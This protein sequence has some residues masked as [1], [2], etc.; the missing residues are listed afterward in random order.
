MAIVFGVYA[1]YLAIVLSVP[2]VLVPLFTDVYGY[3]KALGKFL[4]TNC[5]CK[6]SGLDGYL[7][8]EEMSSCRSRRLQLTQRQSLRPVRSTAAATE[9][10]SGVSTTRRVPSSSHRC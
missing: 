4:P 5:S 2:P 8:R 1:N 9:K 3:A 7:R 6:S 10:R